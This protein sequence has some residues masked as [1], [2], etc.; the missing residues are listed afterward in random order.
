MAARGIKVA[1]IVP[2]GDWRGRQAAPS[3]FPLLVL[4]LIIA[5]IFIARLRAEQSSAGL[6][7]R[8]ALPES[9]R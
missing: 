9:V 1:R 8:S 3:P 4:V 6:A 5:L 2:K 7:M